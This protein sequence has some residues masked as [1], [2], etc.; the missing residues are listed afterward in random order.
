VY[1]VVT[2]STMLEQLAALPTGALASTSSKAHRNTAL[3]MHIP[4][5][6]HGGI[7]LSQTQPTHDGKQV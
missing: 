5:A 4:H 2:D 1:R 6:P 3:H 7:Q